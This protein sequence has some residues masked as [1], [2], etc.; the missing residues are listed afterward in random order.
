[1]IIN[2]TLGGNGGSGGSSD[3]S[4]LD[5]TV[6]NEYKTNQTTIDESQNTAINDIETDITG[7]KSNI[8]NIDTLL[9]NILGE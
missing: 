2:F 7:I 3:P 1:M 4:K 6:F 5:V 9:T 8:G